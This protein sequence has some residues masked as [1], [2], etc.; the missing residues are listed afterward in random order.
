MVPNVN[1]A[2]TEWIDH[3]LLG[4]N[5]VSEI[6][7]A[8]GV[9]DIGD[10]SF[11]NKSSLQTVHLPVSAKRIGSRAFYG[12]DG[13]KNINVPMGTTSIAANA[14]DGCLS[15]V[16]INVVENNPTYSSQDGI[17]FNKA[18]T[19]L[20][21]C[22][23]GKTQSYSIPDG[24]TTIGNHAFHHCKGLEV[25]TIPDGVTGIGTNAF[26]QCTSLT[27]IT[28]PDSI[29]SIENQ[30][31][32]MCT[33]LTAITIPKGVITIGASAFSD[34]TSLK[35]VTIGESVTGIG[36]AAFSDCRNLKS[37]KVLGKGIPV[38]VDVFKNSPA[39]IYFMPG[40]QGWGPVWNDRFVRP[41]RDRQ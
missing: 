8:E 21:R 14:F 35:E 13:L 28:M 4:T 19:N 23:E 37:V 30:A 2:Y 40:A 25:I 20:I 3:D 22:P 26:N 36:T 10:N 27:S 9:T 17:L 15:L 41:I 24:V 7:F 5:A 39:T 16:A 34:C 38:A 6:I 32:R 12:C 1:T 33:K 11:Q 31:F 18:R 29:T